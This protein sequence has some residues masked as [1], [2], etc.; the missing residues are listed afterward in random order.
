MDTTSRTFENNSVLWWNFSSTTTSPRMPP[1]DLNFT[2][3]ESI[4]A[5]TDYIGY[6][7]TPLFFFVGI[8]GKLN[9]FQYIAFLFGLIPKMVNN[10]WMC[11]LQSRCRVPSL[12][13]QLSLEKCLECRGVWKI[14]KLETCLF[15]PWSP[16]IHTGIS[17][18]FSP[19]P[20]FLCA[21][22]SQ[23]V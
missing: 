16:R 4:T 2:T 19:S 1:G 9:I 7:T 18:T 17:R 11:T 15:T 13:A 10:N 12:F 20:C 23:P 14:D 6:V 21:K 5:R 8:I 3:P 22:K